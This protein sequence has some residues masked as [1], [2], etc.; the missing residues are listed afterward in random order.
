MNSILSGFWRITVLVFVALLPAQLAA[1]EYLPDRL[2]VPIGSKHIGNFEQYL[3]EGDTLEE[4][5]FGLIATWRERG[6]RD[7][8]YSVG[9]YRYSLGD[10]AFHASIG[11]T[12][13]VDDDTELGF[14]GALAVPID[15]RSDTKAYLVPSLQINHKDVFFSITGAPYRG[16]LY[17]VIGFG[18][19]I[20]LDF[21]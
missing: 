16:T 12:W 20:D 19:K 7:L 10:P 13:H 11:K 14:V 4:F 18:L 3:K 17:G 2:Y 21:N 9:L 8:D 5:N 1:Q 15:D 6:A